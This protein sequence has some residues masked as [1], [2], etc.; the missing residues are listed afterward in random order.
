[1]HG[2]VVEVGADELALHCQW[3]CSHCRLA[4]LLSVHVPLGREDAFGLLSLIGIG[5][6]D[7]TLSFCNRYRRV[8]S[9]T[10]GGGIIGTA[11]SVCRF[12]GGLPIWSA[13]GCPWKMQREIFL[14][15]VA[16]RLTADM[17]EACIWLGAPIGR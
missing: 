6:D 11:K 5:K 2:S 12:I 15:L 9:T 13:R 1:M 4:G 16:G 10:R 3:L 17:I 7:G 14:A 8:I